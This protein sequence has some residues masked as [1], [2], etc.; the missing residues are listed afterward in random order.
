MC[1]FLLT[2]VINIMIGNKRSSN[3]YEKVKNVFK[4]ICFALIDITDDHHRKFTAMVSDT[5]TVTQ[6]GEL[7][8]EY[9]KYKSF[10]GK[11]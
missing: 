1:P 4:N 3:K 2:T 9:R 8:T 7:M 5:A 11:I 6:F 10:R